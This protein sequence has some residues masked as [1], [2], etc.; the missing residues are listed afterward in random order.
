MIFKSPGMPTLQR[1]A[2]PQNSPLPIGK[3]GNCAYINHFSKIVNVIG[4]SNLGTNNLFQPT[5]EMCDL[6]PEH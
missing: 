5:N 6:P 1:R 2:W 4:F 3:N